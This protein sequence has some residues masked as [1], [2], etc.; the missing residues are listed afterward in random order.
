MS[1]FVTYGKT[2]SGDDLPLLV[3]RSRPHEETV[4]AKY[5]KMLPDE[6]EEVGFVN[7]KTREASFIE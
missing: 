5:R 1:V 3:W 4:D 7:H 6:Y 2:E